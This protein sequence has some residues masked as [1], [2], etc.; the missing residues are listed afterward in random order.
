VTLSDEMLDVRPS[1]DPRIWQRR[2]EV[3]RA[4]GRKRLRALLVVVAVCIV[5][6]AA[7]GA[8]HS[9]LFAAKHFTVTGAVNTPVAE[10]LDSAG[11]LAHPPLVDLNAVRAAERIDALPWIKSATVVAHWPDSVTVSVTERTA[12]V[13]IET[14]GG[15][16]SH[17]TWALVDDT[18]RVLAE[19]ATKPQGLVP[20]SVPVV[21]GS[22]G[23]DLSDSDAPGIDVAATIP[24][25]L[26]ARVE[27]VA[28]SGSGDVTLGLSGGLSADIGSAVDLQAKYEALASV[29]AGVAL[30]SGELID[31]TV[32]G[33][34]TV[35]TAGPS[36]PSN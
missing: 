19:V 1:I 6:A 4:N 34:P 8:L 9:S 12:V 16:S 5:G 11:L 35:G 25:S 28:V 7:L 21:V 22:P 33:E 20:L 26:S 18:G 13:A 14:P 10:V 15:A 3:T 27:S 17:A 29:L 31:V 36:G 23:S 32:P 2:V 30:Q 24:A